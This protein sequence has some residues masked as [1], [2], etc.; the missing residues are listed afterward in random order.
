MLSSQ[1][2]FPTFLTFCYHTSCYTCNTTCIGVPSWLLALRDPCSTIPSWSESSYSISY[3]YA[4]NARTL[5][6]T[7]TCT[8]THTTHTHW[9]THHP[10]PL[11]HTHTHWYTPTPTDTHTTHVATPTNIH[12]H[13][14]WYTHHPHPL[15][16][17]PTL[18]DTHT[19]TPT[20]T[21]THTHWY[22]HHSYPLIHTPTP[23]DTHTYT[24]WYTH[25][26]QM[27]PAHVSG[28]MCSTEC[29]MVQLSVTKTCTTLSPPT[30]DQQPTLITW[31]EYKSVRWHWWRH[32]V[33]FDSMI[34]TNTDICY[35]SL[36]VAM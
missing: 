33:L 19:I 5:L 1:P 34:V 25:H 9:Y 8:C 23:T 29:L 3:T 17:T 20:D 12:T 4:S 14:H 2:C 18:T 15:I 31:R 26:L 10:H 6:P 13:T 32:H 28:V 24:H 11:I 27:I 22:T 36:R 7:I 30:G 35:K 16:C 21:H